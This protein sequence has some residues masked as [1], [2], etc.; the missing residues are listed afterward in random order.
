MGII[1]GPG[2]SVPYKA[3]G[4]SAST[5][6]TLM[7]APSGKGLVLERLERKFFNWQE[8]RMYCL[9]LRDKQEP[10]STMLLQHL[11]T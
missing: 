5:R 8:S 11:S 4:R 10:Q 3:T 6:V 9:E 7:P 1:R 2:N